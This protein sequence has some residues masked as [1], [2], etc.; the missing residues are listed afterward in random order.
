MFSAFV[1]MKAHSFHVGFG[2][3][4]TRYRIVGGQTSLTTLK[5]VFIM[6]SLALFLM[7]NLMQSVPL[8]YFS[9]LAR[10]FSPFAFNIFFSSV[11][12]QFG[13]TTHSVL[14]LIFHVRGVQ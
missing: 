1:Y 10:P 12:E 5:I 13:Y 14:F 2:R 6:F 4:V 11:L 3:F 9:L 7:R 8:F